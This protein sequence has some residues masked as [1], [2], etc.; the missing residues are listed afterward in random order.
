MVAAQRMWKYAVTISTC[1]LTVENVTRKRTT[2][3]GVLSADAKLVHKRTSDRLGLK[4][5]D[6]F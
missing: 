1:G 5:L 2:A 6:E 3:M 4:C